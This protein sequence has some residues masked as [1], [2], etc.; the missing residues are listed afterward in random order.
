MGLLTRTLSFMEDSMQRIISLA[1]I[2]AL[3]GSGCALR[4]GTPAAFSI[5]HAQAGATRNAVDPRDLEDRRKYIEQLPPG[6]RVQIVLADGTRLTG[7]LM[8]V[9]HDVV[10]VQPRTRLP[11]AYR[12]IPMQ[13]IASLTPESGNFNVGQAMAVGVGAGVASFVALFLIVMTVLAD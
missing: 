11:E 3:L 10:I 2:A 12:R 9:E 13:T 7:T 8:G 5:A 6:T 4:R 1:L